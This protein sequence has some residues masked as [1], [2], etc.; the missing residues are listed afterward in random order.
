[1]TTR[2]AQDLVKRIRN[3]DPK[4]CEQVRSNRHDFDLL[5][6]HGLADACLSHFGFPDERHT[7]PESSV[8]AKRAQVMALAQHKAGGSSR[9]QVLVKPEPFLVALNNAT[10]N[11]RVG[12]WDACAVSEKLVPL[13][14]SV[15]NTEERQFWGNRP[16]WDLMLARTIDVVRH[17]I[18]HGQHAAKAVFDAALG[19]LVPRLAVFALHHDFVQPELKVQAFSHAG[20]VVMEYCDVNLVHAAAQPSAA[21]Y[22]T[23]ATVAGLPVPQKSSTFA[24]EVLPLARRCVVERELGAS[25]LDHFSY[26]FCVLVTHGGDAAAPLTREHAGVASALVEMAE[27]A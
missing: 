26:I 20:T 17:C 12:R 22:S 5:L 8:L 21:G 19:D 23:L 4:A 9:Q 7:L 18:L 13:I 27:R 6:Q 15:S 25:V 1:M 10:S 24:R 3:G 16:T 2:D 14:R 11:V